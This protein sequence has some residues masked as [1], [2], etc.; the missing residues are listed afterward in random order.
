MKKMLITTALPYANGPTHLGHLVE[1]IQADIWVR[2]QRLQG[3]D[4]LFVC[5]DDAHGT[6]IMIS[7]EQQGKPPEELI[8]AVHQERLA[9]F[10]N[11]LISFDEYY[12][13]HSPE[14]K[15][16]SS[17]IYQR[18]KERGDISVRTIQQA[19][20][21]TKQMFL[22]DRYVKGNCPRCQASD[23]YGDNC[24]VCGATY[25]PN[26]LI[27]PVSTLSG[28]TPTQKESVHYFFKLANYQAFLSDWLQSDNHVSKPIQNKLMEWFQ[29]SLREWDISRDAPYF[30]FEIPDAPQK[31]FY[32]W[33]D[34]PIGYMAS[35]KKLC[36]SRP[37]LDFNEYW[38]D[39]N[40]TELYHFVGKDIIYF[41]ALFWPAMLHG[42]GFRLPT[43]LFTH[44]F[45]TI[46][47]QKMSKSRG[48]FITAGQYM[49]HL[50]PEY[51]RYYFA[52]KLSSGIEDIDFNI[53]DFSQ[54][55]NADL[56][57]KVV[58]IASR[59]ANF[60]HKYF[61]ST[62][63]SA[64]PRPPLFNLFSS[65]GDIIAEHFQQ[66]DFNQATREI[67]ALADLANQYIDEMK[68]WLL[69]KDPD[70]LPQVQEVCTQGLNL[71]RQLMVY[72]KPILPAMVCQAEEFLQ[73]EPL[74]WQHIHQPL[75]SHQI[76]PFKPLMQR[77]D[78]EKITSLLFG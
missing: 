59:C 42:S 62:L 18:L 46:N 64:L 61:D 19:F 53:D 36:D 37:D 29:D 54:R 45:L 9:D 76:A 77:I 52:V 6:P 16:F 67:M 24:E 56:V 25:T 68:P 4:C 2:F 78:R 8:K 63:A 3:N 50:N 23:Q 58:N 39:D 75:L 11:F 1:H 44:G 5:G 73:I 55:V 66:R 27:D 47:G 15:E 51:L 48:T 33:L 74:T 38:S 49:A 41:H 14:N 43:Q 22:P 71:F 12:T 28:T 31:Y 26:E 40:S 7:A 34:A 30:G 20:D 65:K 69:A 21:S 70:N 10:A 13:T 60:I 57:G 35:F 72:L 32:V 17:L